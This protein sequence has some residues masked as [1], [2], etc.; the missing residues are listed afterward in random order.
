MLWSPPNKQESPM[1]R[2]YLGS[3]G[4]GADAGARVTEQKGTIQWVSSVGG[5]IMPET[6][7]DV[8]EAELDGRG[9]Y[10]PAP[11]HS[12]RNLLRRA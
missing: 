5:F 11:T 1:T 8:P 7:E 9:R 3:L 4:S 6:G 10:L 12:T 2:V